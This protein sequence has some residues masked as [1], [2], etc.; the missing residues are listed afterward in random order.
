MELDMQGAY[1]G[2][3]VILMYG[4]LDAAI[5]EEFAL[6]TQD[7]IFVLTQASQEIFVTE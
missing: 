5:D 4:A 6:L 1:G 7:N 3:I 2:L